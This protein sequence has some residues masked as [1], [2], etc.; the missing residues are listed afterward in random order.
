MDNTKVTIHHLFRLTGLSFFVLMHTVSSLGICQGMSWQHLNQPWGWIGVILLS[1]SLSL[2]SSARLAGIDVIYRFIY[3]EHTRNLTKSI[4]LQPS[5]LPSFPNLLRR[6][7]GGSSLGEVLGRWELHSQLPSRQGMLPQ[8]ASL[9]ASAV[10]RG[11]WEYRMYPPMTGF[12]VQCHTRQCVLH[13]AIGEAC[14]TCVQ[15][16]RHVLRKR[17]RHSLV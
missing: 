8:G 17:E 14:L 1:L 6:F 16:S 5:F 9:P 10:G 11:S 12:A 2:S 3:L 13:S 15:C 4:P 7:R